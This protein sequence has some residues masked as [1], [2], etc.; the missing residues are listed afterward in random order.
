[1]VAEKKGCVKLEVKEGLES[2][3]VEAARCK[4]QDAMWDGVDCGRVEEATT[5]SWQDDY[6]RPQSHPVISYRGQRPEDW[7]DWRL[8]KCTC[9]LTAQKKWCMQSKRGKRKSVGTW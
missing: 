2:S 9:N 7:R 6:A 4:M 3:R 8:W 5:H 1:M